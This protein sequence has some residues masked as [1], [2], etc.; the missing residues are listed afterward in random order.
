MPD[1]HAPALRGDYRHTTTDFRVVQDTATYTPAEHDRWRRLYARQAEICQR[2][3]CAEFNDA[4]PRLGAG[5]G[6][7][8]L[9]L[10][11]ERL[12]AASGWTLVPVPG[13][14][15]DR[16]FFGHLASRRFPVT[17]WLRREEE[18]DYLVEP[19]IFHDFFG[20]VPLLMQPAFARFI[21]RYGEWGLKAANAGELA[22][23]ARLYWYT[24]EFGL[25]QTE[26]GLK[27]YGAGM[28]S[29]ATET[30]HS[31]ASPEPYRIWMQ[32]LRVMNTLYV[33][34]RFQPVYFV[35]RDYA[36]LDAVMDHA[37]EMLPVAAEPTPI[38]PGAAAPGDIALT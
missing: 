27:A 19:D 12:K 6:V 1:T 9:K 38:E 17:V 11:S 8:D 30:A 18:F 4:L 34:D 24:V 36:E 2:F 5:D 26:A 25:I 7:P 21:Q 29:S 28:L 20:H 15:P 16:E 22:R 3:A 10:A 35:I 37:G 14:I 32:P 33:I 13:L 31:V 23:L